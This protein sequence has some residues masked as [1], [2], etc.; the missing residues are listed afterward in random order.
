LMHRS[1]SYAHFFLM[2]YKV[3]H[4]SDSIEK[5]VAPIVEDSGADLVDVIIKGGP[6]G[7]VFQFF[8]DTPAGITVDHLTRLN[9]TICRY[10]EEANVVSSGSYRVEVSSPGLD[11][12][13]KT[14]RDFLRSKGRK[15][16]LVYRDSQDKKA[17]V[18]GT[19]ADADEQAVS[20]RVEG[21]T[22][23]VH[24]SEIVRAKRV[25]KW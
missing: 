18:E 3:E 14:M 4:V 20:L 21:K 9:R 15:V 19:V 22:M 13:L 7:K 12:P 17:D 5:Q 23:A 8:V 24:Y 6:S 16:S 11:R 1:G 10:F 2:G 25:I